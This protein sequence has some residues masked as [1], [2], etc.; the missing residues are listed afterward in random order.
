MSRVHLFHLFHLLHCHHRAA[1]ACVCFSNE[2]APPFRKTNSNQFNLAVGNV[3][4]VSFNSTTRSVF[5]PMDEATSLHGSRSKV[6]FLPFAHRK[7]TRNLNELGLER[8]H[9]YRHLN[10][11]SCIKTVW[12]SL[13][14]SVSAA[15]CLFAVLQY[16][17]RFIYNLCNAI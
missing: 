16:S 10:T 1:A 8:C 13:G 15:V 6:R 12:I 5:A 3:S 9:I 4:C 14:L 2:R 11:W 17:P 7:Q